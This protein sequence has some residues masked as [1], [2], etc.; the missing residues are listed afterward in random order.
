MYV[1]NFRT[2]KDI[3]NAI[4]KSAEQHPEINQNDI[5]VLLWQ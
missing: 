1:P 5:Q 4:F 3:V 2:T